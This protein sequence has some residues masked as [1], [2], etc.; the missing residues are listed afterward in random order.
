MRN[1]SRQKDSHFS[2]LHRGN[3]GTYLWSFGK[4]QTWSLWRFDS[5]RGVYWRNK[6]RAREAPYLASLSWQIAWRKDPRSPTQDSHPSQSTHAGLGWNSQS[7][8]DR[9]H[10]ST[11]G[12]YQSPQSPS[13]AILIQIQYN[14]C[15]TLANISF[16]EEGKE[17]IVAKGYIREIVKYISNSNKLVREA[18]TL[19]LCS[20]AQLNQG[21]I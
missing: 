19:L 20:L 7:L 2:R 4:R 9:S 13:K 5:F 18:S 3:R 14:V 10:K 21:K 8:E 15:I 12:P 11:D 1:P 6:L 16:N 17:A